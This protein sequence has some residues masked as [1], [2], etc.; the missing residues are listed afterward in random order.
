MSAEIPSSI[1]NNIIGPILTL[2]GGGVLVRWQIN[3]LLKKSEKN[4]ND[5]SSVKE[6]CDKN[7]RD[8]ALSLKDVE[9]NTSKMIVESMINISK[10]N[11]ESLLKI[12]EAFAKAMESNAKINLENRAHLESQLQLLKNELMGNIDKGDQKIETLK[13]QIHNIEIALSKVGKD[14]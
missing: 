3:H 11:Q 13:N 8:G 4:E 12:T 5:I 6:L 9:I 14:V 1:L 10:M 7:S 2:A